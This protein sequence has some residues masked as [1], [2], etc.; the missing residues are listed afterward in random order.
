MRLSE[1][2]HLVWINIIG[3]R[4]KVLLTS[5]GIIVGS[6]TI[7]LV[8]AIG[9]GGQMDVADQFRNLSAGSIDITYAG[10]A[11]PEGEFEVVMFGAGRP[12]GGGGGRPI[13]ASGMM[14]ATSI[15]GFSEPKNIRL[16]QSDLEDLQLFIPNLYAG[17]LSVTAKK[18]VTGG[19]LTEGTEYNIAGVTN[20]FSTVS[21][22]KLLLG[23]FIT[24][25]DDT[26]VNKVAVLGYNLAMEIFGSPMAAYDSIIYIDGRQFVVNGVLDRMGTVTSGISP[27]DSI[28]IPYSSAKKYVMG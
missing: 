1:I 2:L 19:D 16:S 23:D 21:N 25:E 12:Q 18:K 13:E 27:D 5:L 20:G 28:F 6:A 4:F 9:R 17:S 22:L 15:Y 24:E 7:V 8:I 26:A 11:P 14:A 10:D 3:N